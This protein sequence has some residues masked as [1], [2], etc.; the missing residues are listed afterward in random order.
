MKLKTKIKK[1]IVHGGQVH[2]DDIMCIA[3]ALNLE[4]GEGLGAILNPLPVFRR[5]PT[6]EEMDDMSVLVM[7]V[8]GQHAP[9][10]NNYDH[11]L[12]VVNNPPICALTLYLQAKYPERLRQLRAFTQWFKVMEFIDD[13]GPYEWAKKEGLRGF[14]F[15]LLGPVEGAIK[16]MI[17]SATSEGDGALPADLRQFL[18][19]VGGN[20]IEYLDKQQAAITKLRDNADIVDVDGVKGI[21]YLSKDTTGLQMLRDSKAS[22]GIEYAFSISLD[23]RGEGLALYR[24]NDDPRVNFAKLTGRANIIFAH[25]GGFIAKTGKGITTEMALQLVKECLVK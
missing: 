10:L 21:V 18:A 9:L 17:E 6:V 19:G 3:L 12:G 22:E 20:T 23:D 7:D 4:R 24:F 16:A 5:D 8:G 2:T 11:H 15:G 1:I 14:P 25:P 13:R